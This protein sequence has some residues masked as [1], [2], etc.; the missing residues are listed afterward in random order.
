MAFWPFLIILNFSIYQDLS[1]H[2]NVL[3]V[4]R[5]SQNFLLSSPNPQTFSTLGSLTISVYHVLLPFSINN[6]CSVPLHAFHP[7]IIASLFVSSHI[8]LL[9]TYTKQLL[10]LLPLYTYLSLSTYDSQA[11][12]FTLRMRDIRI[13]LFCLYIVYLRY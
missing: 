5:L 11:V 9:S 12:H 7:G 3:S 2:S 13:L 8:Y 4:L 1:D 10:K 6:R